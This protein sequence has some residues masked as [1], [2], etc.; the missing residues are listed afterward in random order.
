M[1]RSSERAAQNDSQRA[2]SKHLSSDP[3]YVEVQSRSRR[4]V[5][6]NTHGSNDSVEQTAARKQRVGMRK[7]SHEVQAQA[8]ILSRQQDA[9]QIYKEKQIKRRSKGKSQKDASPL[10]YRKSS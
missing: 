1:E 8:L 3:D 10:G 6:L 7:Q 4:P 9:S 2:V 5:A